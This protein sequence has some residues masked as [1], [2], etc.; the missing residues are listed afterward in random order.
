MNPV[1]LALGVRGAV[2]DLRLAAEA[3]PAAAEMLTG[4]L[5]G[6]PD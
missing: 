1:G 3:G 4:V 2:A 6:S 5:R